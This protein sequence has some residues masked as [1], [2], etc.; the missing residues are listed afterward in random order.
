M[1]VETILNPKPVVPLVCQCMYCKQ[2][3]EPGY[4][5]T[6]SAPVGPYNITSGLCRDC[7]PKAAMDMELD[8]DEL[9]RDWDETHPQPEIETD[10]EHT[11]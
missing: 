2:L 9:Y 10:H 8:V 6:R 4:R 11:D 7:V 5:S 1:T 3:F